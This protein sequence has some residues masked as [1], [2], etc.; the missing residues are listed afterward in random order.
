MGKERFKPG[1]HKRGV[2]NVQYTS[3]KLLNLKSLLGSGNVPA[4]PPRGLKLKA[5]CNTKWR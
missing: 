2:P 1:L 3:E 4:Y 5:M